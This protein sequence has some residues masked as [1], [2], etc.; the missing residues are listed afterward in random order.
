M[1][2]AGRVAASLPGRPAANGHGF[3]HELPGQ[4]RPV[5]RQ[6]FVEAFA[7][8]CGV[9]RAVT[10]LGVPA[11]SYEI[12]RSPR[13]D[14]LSAT[15]TRVLRNDIECGRIGC[16]WFGITCASW[17]L[18]R[19]GKPDY[20][21]YP[22]PLRDSDAFLMGLPGL[23]SK[24]RQRVALGNRQARWLVGIIRLC[25]RWAVPVVV[26]NPASSRLW[27]YLRRRLGEPHCDT[28]FC[29]CRYGAGFKKATRLWSWHVSLAPLGLMC[30]GKKA[31]KHIQL[32]GSDG[33]AFRT[34]YGAEYPHSFCAAA[35]R[36][37]ALACQ[38]SPSCRP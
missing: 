3:V 33:K 35:A 38:K 27:L 26:E 21:G 23:S 31:C 29:H 17:S 16:L 11:E 4:T 2:E 30:L 5:C 8:T 36:V 24:D 20:S 14:L 34:S 18:A 25:R 6:R 22:P 7:G 13:E 19:R 28:V 1:T 9:A 37:L 15:V 32:S 10:S 12:E